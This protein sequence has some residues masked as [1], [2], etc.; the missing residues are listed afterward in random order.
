MLLLG[1]VVLFATKINWNAHCLKALQCYGQA[2]EQISKELS[3]ASVKRRPSSFK[4]FVTL[5]PMG[6]NDSK[7]WGT[8]LCVVESSTYLASFL[9]SAAAAVIDVDAK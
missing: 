6:P 3:V 4:K 7:A 8:K 1:S 2:L 9:V 5:E